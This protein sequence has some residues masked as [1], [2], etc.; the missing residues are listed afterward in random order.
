VPGPLAGVHILEIGG[1]GP[2]PFAGMMLADMGATVTRIDS[3]GSTNFAPSAVS[4]RGRRSLVLNLRDSDG[5]R[6]CTELIKRSD[7]ACEGFRP[8]VAERLGIGP[9]K[10]LSVNPRLVYGRMTGWGQTGPLAQLGG[11][12]INY[13]SLSGALASL[14]DGDELP[15]P[16]LNLLGD[17]AGG[18]MILAYGLVCALL[19]ASRSG[20]GRVVDAAMVTDRHCCSP[21]RS[22][23]TRQGPCTSPPPNCTSGTTTCTEPPMIT[24]SRPVLSRPS[25]AKRFA[26]R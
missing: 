23:A 5:V 26:R 4:L 2:G 16:P 25:S 9:S 21:R 24:S 8:G 15:R 19:E 10:C 11:H 22:D 1:I 12:D 20:T 18:G 17:Y 7:A 6:I 14:S 3:V 13:I